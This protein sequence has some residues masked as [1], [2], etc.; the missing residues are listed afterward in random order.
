MYSQGINL[1]RPR[2]QRKA[3]LGGKW[4]N[5][6]DQFLKEIVQEHGAKCW[7]K[8]AGLLGTTRTDVQCL[9]RWNKVLKV[10][11]PLP[12]P[13][14]PLHRHSTSSAWT[15]QRHLDQRGGRCGAGA[16]DEAG[17]GQGEVVWHRG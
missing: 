17:S 9:H 10:S 6:E 5:E 4:S 3:S 14:L 2:A 8:V 11:A 16:G 15:A 7:K 13:A 12:S 1:A